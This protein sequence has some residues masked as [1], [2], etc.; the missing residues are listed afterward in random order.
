[1]VTKEAAGDVV[2]YHG[3]SVGQANR[4]AAFINDHIAAVV[5]SACP[6]AVFDDKT[7]RCKR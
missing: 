5:R 1:M 2:A 6:D 7:I 4:Y 3:P